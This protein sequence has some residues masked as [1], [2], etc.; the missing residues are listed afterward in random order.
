MVYRIH[1]LPSQPIEDPVRGE[2]LEAYVGILKVGELVR[3]YQIPHRDFDGKTGYQRLP[4]S[5]RVKKLASALRGNNVDL[6]TAVLLSVRDRDLRPKH[7]STGRY[8]LALPEDGT[9]PF[10]VV[11]GQHRLEALRMV[12]EEDQDAYW[13]E[14]RIPTVIFFGSDEYVEMEQFHTVNANAKSIPTGL[15]FDLLKTRAVRDDSFW[16]YLEGAGEGWKVVSQNL[17]EKVSKRGVWNGRIRFSNQRKGNTLIASNSFVSSLKP[18]IGQAIFSTYL[19]EERARI[20][21]AYWRGIAKSLPEC[22]RN[23]DEYNIQKTVG[24]YMLHDLLPTVLS[25]ANQFGSP[26]FEPET[27]DKI[28]RE[29][30]QGL[31]G[32]N[33]LGGDAV[34]SEFWRVGGEG[35]AGAYSSGAGRRVLREKIK[36]ELQQNLMDQLG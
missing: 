31:R 35:A 12:I 10:Y 22:F 6:P 29:T 14:Y 2:K 4:T 20:V 3:R 18:V 8:I 1:L 19:P 36:G 16:K 11:D 5:S 9:R 34:G 15:A 32:D 33:S 28:L 25:Y 17:T 30:L 21:D 23:P 13:S 26:V 7:D 24:V 27:Y